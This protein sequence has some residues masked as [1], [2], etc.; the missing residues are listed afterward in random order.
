MDKS[1]IDAASGG[2]L[3]DK[4][5]AVARHLISNMASNTQQFGVRGPSP[6][7]WLENQLTELTTST[8]LGSK[9]MWHLYF[10]GAPHG[11]VPHASRN[12]VGP[13]RECWSN[14]VG[15]LIIRRMQ[16]NHFG[17]D[18]I[19]GLM[20]LNNLGPHRMRIKDNKQH[21]ILVEYDR[22]HPRPQDV[23]RTVSQHCEP[24]TASWI[25]QPSFSNNSESERERKCSYA[26]KWKR[27]ISTSTAVAEISRSQL[28][29][30][31]Q[32]DKSIFSRII[33]N[34]TLECRVPR[35]RLVRHGL[36][37]TLSETVSAKCTDATESD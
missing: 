8:F 24:I 18:R 3:M 7:G 12:R 23:D 17:Q 36:S 31:C 4:T 15:H 16:D 21:A 20:Q 10:R 25:Q 14:R 32:F 6:P 27:T 33:K 29:I 22:H 35:L 11:Y 5:P 19:K 26:E 1:M 9:S 2:A 13:A 30:G 37:K 28:Q 34:G